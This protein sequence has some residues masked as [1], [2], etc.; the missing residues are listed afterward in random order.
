MENQFFYWFILRNEFLRGNSK[1]FI[2]D[3]G[4][5][6][7]TSANFIFEKQVI[8]VHFPKPEDAGYIH[9]QQL[10][11]SFKFDKVLHNTGQD[12]VYDECAYPI[13]RSLLDGYNGK[14]MGFYLF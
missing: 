3:H 5:Y 7:N 13:V 14:T 1:G 2:D 6:P 10:D 12:V 9:N 11:W 4:L 8:N